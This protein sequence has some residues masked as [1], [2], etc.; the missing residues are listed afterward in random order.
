MTREEMLRILDF[1]D[2]S[3]EITETR[4]ALSAT[5]PRWNIISYA[6]RRHLEG[7]LLTITSTAMAAGVPYG[8][9]MRRIND[10]IDQGFL[11]K[12]PRSRTGKSFSLHPTRKL[13]EE[14]EAFAMQTKAMVGSTFGFTNGDGGMEDFYFGGYYMASRILS[15][16]NAMRAGP[17]FDRTVR[18]LCPVDPTFRTISKSS[19]I[20]TELCGTN[21]DIVTLPLDELHREILANAERRDPEYDLLAIDLPWIGQL[22]EAGLIRPID[23]ILR[24][25]RYNASDFHSA[26]WKGSAYGGRQFGL[27]IQP[28]AELLYCRADLFA[29]AG[30]PIPE[31]TDEVLFAARM[32][33]RT[34]FGLSGIVMNFARGTP[35]AHT[36]VQTLADFG[37]PVI[38]L[39]ARG[40][41]FDAETIEGENFRPMIDTEAGL[42]TADYLMTLRDYA[43]P[44]SL[45]CAWDDR[46]RLFS[47]G[48][49]AMTYGWTVRAAA[50]E[51]DESSPAH[52]NVAFVAHPRGPGARPVS[53]I[54]GFCLTVPA[55]LAED[56]RRAA[57]K[58]MEYLCRPELLK[59]YV[60]DGNLTSPRFSTSADPEVRAMS[61]MIGRVDAMERRGEIQIWP[62]PPVPEFSDI[63]QVLGKEIHEMLQGVQS[64]PESLQR[65]QNRIDAIM[66]ENGRY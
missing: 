5:D 39:N 11:L 1:A 12:R 17:G 25:D 29:E 66:R 32:L 44:D 61:R 43:H 56:R 47:E 49:A 35:V 59:W 53:P 19:S 4:T 38:D 40:D 10:L 27:P 64:V 31:T 7:K 15:Y 54:G 51:L 14:F 26:A 36:F 41:E 60:Q 6:M 2:R 52:G 62:R 34:G 65:A 42:R 8:T 20:L 24:A 37:Q 13:I 57:W 22:A 3:R 9:A 21:L 55:G 45:K 48:R 46:I 50:F 28:T 33:H 63:L 23:D 16:P 58:V 18:I 30:L